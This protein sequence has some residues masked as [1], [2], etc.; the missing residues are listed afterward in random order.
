MY[1]ALR[2]TSVTLA[3]F[4]RQQLEADP[5]LG[6]FFNGALGGTMVVRLNTPGEMQQRQIE[7]L[8]VWLYRVVRD[9][10]RLN[11]PARRITP[12]LVEEP[13][14]PMRLHYLMTPLTN[15]ALVDGPETEQ[16][17]MG[18]VL[19][20]LHTSPILRGAALRGDFA[21]TEV[22]LDIHLE[23]MSLEEITQVWDALGGSYQLS[24]SY[25]VSVVDIESELTPTAAHP[26]IVSMPEYGIIVSRS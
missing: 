20:I 9:E 6:P 26:V 12:L 19:Q 17:I 14:L 10:D 24:V 11:A 23:P 25:E 13:P 2:A 22:E 15:P 5:V 21:G 8:S 16:V 3:G 7:G 18:K 1:T 4:L